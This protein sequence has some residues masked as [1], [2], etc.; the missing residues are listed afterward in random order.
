MREEGQNDLVMHLSWIIHSG[1]E[2]LNP[3]S[4]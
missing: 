4:L 1:G 2:S 3:Q